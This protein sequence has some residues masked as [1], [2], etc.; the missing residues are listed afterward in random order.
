M[1]VTVRSFFDS[2]IERACLVQKQVP[3]MRKKVIVTN[4]DATNLH[5]GSKAPSSSVADQDATSTAYT[6][7][8]PL[9][10]YIALGCLVLSLE[11]VQCP[12]S[13]P[14]LSKSQAQWV[15][16]SND[17]LLEG[18]CESS[19][20]EAVLSLVNAGWIKAFSYSPSRTAFEVWRVYLLADDV[21]RAS[22]DGR[23]KKHAKQLQNIL[24]SIDTRTHTWNKPE[25][26]SNVGFHGF[27]IWA[28]SENSS[29]FYL[30]NT[31]SSPSPDPQC[32][33]NR[34]LRHSVQRLLED[35]TPPWGLKTSLYPYQRRCAAMMIQ[36]ENVQTRVLDPRLEKR[37][38]PTGEDFYYGPRDGVFF[39]SPRY[40]ESSYGGI[41]A[42][43]MGLGKTLI[44]IAMIMLTRGQYPAKPLEYESLSRDSQSRSLA[45]I[46]AS[47]AIK[48]GLPWKTF[49]DDYQDRTD[50]DMSSCKVVMERQRPNY[51]I[52]PKVI[53]SMR[54]SEKRGPAE[55]IRQCHGTIVV[56][57]HNLLHQWQS[58][59]VKHVK[60]GNLKILVMKDTKVAL[61]MPEEL[62]KYDVVLFSRRR[63]ELENRAIVEVDYVSPLKKL[64]WLRIIVDEGH[65]FSSS[66]TNAAVVAEKLVRAERRWVV[67]GTPARDLLGVEV[68]VPAMVDC[69]TEEDFKRYK[70]TSLENRRSFDQTQ[71]RST[72]AVKSIGALASKFLRV[73][74]WC[75]S[76]TDDGG[77]NWDDYIFRHEDHYK[78]TYTGFSQCLRTTLDDIIIKTRPEDVDK[79]L[80]LPPLRH[81]TVRL[82]PSLVDKMTAN[83]FVLLY[84][85]NAV[86]S[87]RRDQDYL[88]HSSSR[89]HLQRLT[90][91]LR[92]SAFFWTGFSETDVST[93]IE[94]GHKYLDKHGTNC[95]DND[96][97]ALLNTMTSAQQILD[98]PTWKA[99]SRSQ[100][101]GIFLRGWPQQ[102]RE[103][104]A[105]EGCMN[106]PMMGLSLLVQAMKFVNDQLA[107]DDPLLGFEEAGMAAKLRA[108]EEDLALAQGTLVRDAEGTKS[109]IGV[110]SAGYS[111][112]MG[113]KRVSVTGTSKATPKKPK[114][115]ADVISP[116]SPDTP[117]T[118]N[119]KPKLSIGNSSVEL[120]ASDPLGSAHIIG[121][122]S[123]KFSYLMDR[124]AAL[125][126]EEKILVFYDADYI[127]YYLSQAFDL[128]NIKHLIYANTLNAEQRSKYVVLFD[129]DP[130]HRVLLMDI[131]QAAHGLN[132]SSASRVFFVNP[133]WRP[134]V[135]AQAMKRAHRIGQT[136]PVHVE[137]L[138]L[139]STVEEAMYERAA[140]MTRRE[141]LAAKNLEEDEDIRS[142]IQNSKVIP[143]SPQELIGKAQMSPLKTP[144]QVFG[145]PGRAS[146][147]K[148]G[149]MEEEVFG[150]KEDSDNRKSKKK[151]AMGQSSRKRKGQG[152]ATESQ[153]VEDETVEDRDAVVLASPEVWAAKRQQE[154]SS[155]NDGNDNG[156]GSSAAAA[157]S[158]FGG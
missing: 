79:D 51:E 141:H 42:E 3:N 36:K 89:S 4:S 102:A 81:D 139:K 109:K 31:L 17:S 118:P 57:P 117:K 120:S 62:A 14:A 101:M 74:P 58:E 145:R 135:E 65:G 32:I 43:T 122:S 56:V 142:I 9:S 34:H 143:I 54:H 114:R 119:K 136:R 97:A 107:T 140:R 100:D 130:A 48:S 155:R 121:S 125:H 40:Y 98:S 13:A 16:L 67:T 133:P 138:V 64:H 12:E 104:W 66:T 127:A 116:A 112:G 128:L 108:Q 77:A 46:A 59:L 82:D 146:K 144:Q 8:R 111:D 47:A 15:P 27:D 35:E 75:L 134:D 26:A 5:D 149:K 2:F 41:L 45:D 129:T 23:S 156:A 85:T 21:A 24:P 95:T 50:E 103:A 63:F 30:F 70:D 151:K 10:E 124:V 68:D 132:L 76:H 158:L 6:Q 25:A 38:S 94:T 86:T 106:P 52:P 18:H 84:T 148:Q 92:H 72:G 90:T 110:P 152:K 19:T 33:D 137:T 123:A 147:N 49:F 69:E 91:N 37:R 113:S 88:F 131:K 105:F 28:T 53:R 115:K 126:E 96:R 29:L 7:Q 44:C 154:M 1:T 157:W 80:K 150:N 93:S 73:K 87:E 61:P 83:I 11:P 71:E 22:I 20:V 55:K 60:E 99:L 78:R 153:G 39:K